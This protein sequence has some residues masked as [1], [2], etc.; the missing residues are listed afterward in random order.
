MGIQLWN[1]QGSLG[2]LIAL[3]SIL[4]LA[5]FAVLLKLNKF[6]LSRDVILAVLLNVLTLFI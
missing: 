5:I 4:D 6:F 3:G 2:K 1:L